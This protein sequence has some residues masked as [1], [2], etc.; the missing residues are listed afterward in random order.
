MTTALSQERDYPSLTDE[1]ID[2]ARRIVGVRLR[3]EAHHHEAT[4]PAISAWVRSIGDRNPLYLEESYAKHSG[5]GMIV[6]PP[7]WLYS[8]DDTVIAPKLPGIHTIY[9]GA[10]WEFFKPIRIGDQFQAMASLTDVQEKEGRFCG[11]LVL[12]T[13]EVVY[14]NQRADVVAI[15][16][17]KILRTPR[18]AAQERGKYKDWTQYHYSREELS[19]IE[20]AYDAEVI[21]GQEIR[22][23]EDTQVGEE[24][25]PVLKGPLTSEDLVQFVHATHPVPG[26]K[27]FV[28]MKRR[29]PLY[30]F[31]EP[32]NNMWDSW[33]N[34][35]LEDKV[36][37]RMGFPFAHDTGIQRIAWLGHLVTN[38]MGDD[39]SLKRMGAEVRL[40]NVFGDTQWCKGRVKGKY[41]ENGE[42]LVDLEIW[43]ENQRGDMTTANGYAVVSLASRSVPT[44]TILEQI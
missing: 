5:Y 42:D 4:K 31:R 21:R 25:T 34:Q 37:R 12:Q 30:A 33:E 17:P 24:L 10:E 2:E 27:R 7:L 43:C 28:E 18:K 41:Q 13:G 15:A 14:R 6:A 39:G 35:L 8:V 38:W 29:H 22:Y 19:A 20:D 40:P 32:D 36:A 9:A 11:R 44:H 16:R 1:A 23:W 3:R 26:F